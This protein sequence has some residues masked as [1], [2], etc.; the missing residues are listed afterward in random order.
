MICLCPA[1]WQFQQTEILLQFWG[2]APRKDS[3]ALKPST[4]TAPG[5]VSEQMCRDGAHSGQQS[6]AVGYL[7]CRTEGNVSH[8]K[9][10]P[11]KS[12]QA[13]MLSLPL[14]AWKP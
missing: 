1:S 13:I 14:S 10:Q 5:K 12:T 8:S 9:G 6:E 11:H 3:A 4:V 7:A 2:L